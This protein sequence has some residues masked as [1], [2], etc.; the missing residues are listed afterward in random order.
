MSE[1]QLTIHFRRE[2]HEGFYQQPG[3]YF[4]EGNFMTFALP[5][6]AEMI[7]SSEEAHGWVMSTSITLCRQVQWARLSLFLNNNIKD[8]LEQFQDSNFLK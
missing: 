7:D 4:K 8:L 3:S 1:Q 6:G 5:F 2:E